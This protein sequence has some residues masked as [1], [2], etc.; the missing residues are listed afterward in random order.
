MYGIVNLSLMGVIFNRQNT[1]VMRYSG[2]CR[3]SS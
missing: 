3:N 2:Y 1:C